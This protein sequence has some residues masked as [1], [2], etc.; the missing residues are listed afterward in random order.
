M[1]ANEGK[2]ASVAA[3]T[4]KAEPDSKAKGEVI[5]SQDTL[6]ELHI[7]SS[8]EAVWYKN[9]INYRTVLVAHIFQ[10]IPQ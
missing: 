8:N 9:P 3:E 1:Q 2:T 6:W 7:N 5:A 4:M 10:S